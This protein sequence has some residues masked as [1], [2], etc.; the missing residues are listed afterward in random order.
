MVKISTLVE[1]A[2]GCKSYVRGQRSSVIS[3]LNVGEFLLGYLFCTYFNSLT[4]VSAECVGCRSYRL[5][6]NCDAVK[7]LI[8]GRL[9]AVRICMINI[10]ALDRFAF[11]LDSYVIIS[12]GFG[13]I[14]GGQGGNGGLAIVGFYRGKVALIV[15]FE[16]G[17]SAYAVHDICKLLIVVIGIVYR[18]I[19]ASALGHVAVRVLNACYLDVVLHGCRYRFGIGVLASVSV[20]N[21][22]IDTVERN[23][24]YSALTVVCVSHGIV[25]TLDLGHNV[26]RTGLSR[27]V[28]LT[29]FGAMSNG[30]Y[31]TVLISAVG[32]LAAVGETFGLDRNS[33]AL[34][35][36][37]G[38]M[39]AAFV[40][41]Y[42]SLAVFI[43]LILGVELG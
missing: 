12:K 5:S 3:K 9:V 41:G 7:S 35:I 42:N 25:S 39:L 27:A 6:V 40:K 20:G 26:N 10:L 28:L 13:V 33:V 24:A 18:S 30:G 29:V 31:C 11:Q 38:L 34:V 32:E 36:K 21:V 15:V 17:R 37:C 8:G 43:D 4:R 2:V 1:Y 23:R 19:A 22:I 14:R 16:R